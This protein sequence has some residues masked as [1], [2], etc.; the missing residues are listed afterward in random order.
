MDHRGI[1]RFRRSGHS[2]VEQQDADERRLV[3]DG[4][5]EE[6]ESVAI[7][8]Q[9]IATLF[10]SAAICDHLRSSASRRSQ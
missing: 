8:V 7:F 5:R 10:S 1:A 4:R 2:K 3:A 6:Q 9:K